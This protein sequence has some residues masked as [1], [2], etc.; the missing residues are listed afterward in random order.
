MRLAAR[1][2]LPPWR[3]SLIGPVS[4]VQGGGGEAYRDS[5]VAKYEPQ[6]G[7]RLVFLPPVFDQA[8]LAR[9]YGDLDIFCYPSLAAKGEGLSIAPIEAMAAGAVPVV[10]TLECY[11]DL[12]VPPDNGFQF[13]QTSPGAVNEL[14]AIFIRL[15]L[16]VEQRRMVSA[17]AQTTAHRFDY[18]ETA[19]LLLGEFGRLTTPGAQR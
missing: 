8:A 14:T 12:I 3:L 1:P 9:H 11:R 15:L 17:R 4:V 18:A 5:L 13:D 6:L 7:A 16:D 19:R 10:S 2:D